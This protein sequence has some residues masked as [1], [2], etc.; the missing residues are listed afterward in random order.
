[1]SHALTHI[2]T[3]STLNFESLFFK[4]SKPGMMVH[5]CNHSTQETEAG[6]LRI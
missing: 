6:E 1:L 4:H 5:T 2:I 3:T